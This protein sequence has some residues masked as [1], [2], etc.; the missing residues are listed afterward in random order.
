MEAPSRQAQRSAETRTVLLRVARR[1]FATRGYAGTATE[2]VVRR[3]RMTRGALYHHFRDK[4]DLFVA[5][6]QQEQQALAAR[7][8]EAA[9]G[10]TDPWRAMV[11][12][13]NAFLD[14]CLDP[15]VQQIVLVDAPAVLG[16]ERWRE[17]D[18]GYYMA[19]MKAMIQ[20]AVAQGLIEEQ[21]VEPLAHIIFGALHE[22]AMLIARSEDKAATRQAISS[23][24]G[25][26]F[27]G[28]RGGERA[29]KR[30]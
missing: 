11:A 23:V 5:V 28:L 27:E 29:E 26:L 7:A 2:E 17:D 1:L 13:A 19:G 3:A 21:P 9:A 30:L 18:Q 12:A 24:V 20:A 8:K 14:G 25:R 15:A 16:L 6:W 22:A 4:Q 10:E